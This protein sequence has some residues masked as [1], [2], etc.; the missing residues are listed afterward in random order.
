M[1]WFT[2]IAETLRRGARGIAAEAVSVAML[3][4]LAVAVAVAVAAI[5]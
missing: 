4:A 2:E 5:F 1:G 3:F